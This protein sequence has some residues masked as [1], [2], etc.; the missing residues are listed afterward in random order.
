MQLQRVF[1]TLIDRPI[2]IATLKFFLSEQYRICDIQSR[3]Q[4]FIVF[5][6]LCSRPHRGLCPCIDPVGDGIHSFVP[7]RNKFLATPL[8][9][10][11]DSVLAQY[12]CKSVS[13]EKQKASKT[14][15]TWE[16]KNATTLVMSTCYAL[17]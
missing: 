1:C 11:R 3:I 7:L 5:L 9:S 4:H 2:E 8:L 10:F 12:R 13:K 15:N 14:F 6:G 17:F 16:N